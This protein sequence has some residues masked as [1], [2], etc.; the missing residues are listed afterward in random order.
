MV[1][2]KQAQEFYYRLCEAYNGDGNKTYQGIVGIPHIADM[3][4]IPTETA[5]EFCHAMVEYNIT[6]R[7]GG[8]YVI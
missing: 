4:N 2:K 3:M 6:E 5:T 1:T 7:Q 8:G